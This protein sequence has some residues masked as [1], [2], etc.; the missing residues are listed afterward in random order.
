MRRGYDRLAWVEAPNATATM[1]R[2]IDD[3]SDMGNWTD[4]VDQF[5]VY[6]EDD[7]PAHRGNHDNTRA[8]MRAVTASSPRGPSTLD[9]S[10]HHRDAGA[11]PH[12]AYSFP[13]EGTKLAETRLG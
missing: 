3:L 2:T 13:V 7:A 10:V 11:L 9:W 12:A 5:S 1:Q 8:V 4:D 6:P